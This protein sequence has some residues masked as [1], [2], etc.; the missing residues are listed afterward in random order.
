MTA[1]LRGVLGLGFAMEMAGWIMMFAATSTSYRVLG[2][3]LIIGGLV[4]WL[5]I[6][7]TIARER[8]RDH[9]EG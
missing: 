5:S 3:V 4:P 2:G 1:R 6:R 7:E 8:E 9:R